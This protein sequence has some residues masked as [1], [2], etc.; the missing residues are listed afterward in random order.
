M[1]FAMAVLQPDVVSFA[2]VAPTLIY[3]AE[4]GAVISLA[5]L[6]WWPAATDVSI[7]REQ[8]GTSVPEGILR[9]VIP[10]APATH[11]KALSLFG[12]ISFEQAVDAALQL[13]RDGFAI[14]PELADS[15]CI[16]AQ[17]VA[18]YAENKAIFLKNG[19]P[20][21]A[22]A[23]LKQTNLAK[24]IGRL[25]QAER[26]AAGGRIEKL[27]AVHDYFYRGPIASE[28]DAWHRNNGGFMRRE[29]LEAFEVAAEAS[30]SCDY[31]GVTVHTCDTW[32]QGI[33]LL[34]ALKVLEDIDLVSLG[35]NSPDYLHVLAEALNL[36]FADREYYVGDPKFMHVPV[37]VLLSDAYASKQ[38]ARI[39]HR[40]AEGK[41]YAGGGPLDGQLA[42]SSPAA[43]APGSVP[44]A[45]DTIYGC[46]VDSRG[47]AVSMTPSD[48][49]WDSPMVDGLG[50]ALSTRGMQSRLDEDHASFVQPGK[51][52]RLTP[53]PTMALRD[54]KFEMGWGTPGGDVQ[55]SAML[56]VFLNIKHFGMTVQQAIEAPRVAPFS[57]P[58]SFAPNQYYPGRLCVEESIAEATRERLAC[59]GHDVEVWPTRSWSAGAVCMVMK[60]IETG[61][62][63]AGA[64][65]RRAAYAAVW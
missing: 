17:E 18:R 23:L 58:N 1:G 33:V 3:Q 25:V 14:H 26:D 31:Q 12:T 42:K 9:Q 2:G 20:P 63:H 55:C 56:Q 41:M 38:R 59:M 36:A 51:R 52:P 27:R 62:L 15:L 40:L 57:F 7:L 10:A 35:H 65:P 11:L 60:D 21:K 19:V 6:G 50:L 45:P 39:R 43:H 34:Q 30:I 53:S 8:G 61:L 4:T 44:T 13:A 37:D 24:T 22:G 49:M 29:D 54:G 16:H 28:I 32:C 48:T 46:V 64:D 47:N 5:G